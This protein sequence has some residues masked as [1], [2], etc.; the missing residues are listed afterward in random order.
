MKK[1]WILAVSLLVLSAFVLLSCFP[2]HHGPH[3]RHLPVPKHVPGPKPP[4][5]HP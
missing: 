3:P 2:F 4:L 1:A 5:P